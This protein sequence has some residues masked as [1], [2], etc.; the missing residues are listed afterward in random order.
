MTLDSSTRT[1]TIQASY[2]KAFAFLVDPSN[3]AKWAVG[4]IKG[5]RMDGDTFMVTTPMGEISYDVKGDK[6]TGLL[7]ILLG[8]EESIPTRLLRN[9][10][11]VDFLFTFHRQPQ[12]PTEV[13]KGQLKELDHELQVLKSILEQ[14]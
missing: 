9:Q 8:G 6:R 12:V 13:F 2:D 3:H 1:V 11:G 14:Q 4:F 5:S 7:D 10:D